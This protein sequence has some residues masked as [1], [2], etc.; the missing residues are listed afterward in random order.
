[1]KGSKL[2][3]CLLALILALA[4]ALGSCVG[5]SSPMPASTVAPMPSPSLRTVVAKPSATPSPT[6]A[7]PTRSEPT[8]GVPTATP[9]YTVTPTGAPTSVPATP[10]PTLPPTATA[11]GSASGA[12]IS[13]SSFTSSPAEILPGEAVTLTWHSTGEWATIY[14]LDGDGRMSEPWFKVGPSGTLVVET[15]SYLRNSA[16]F[17]LFAGTGEESVA[18]TASV[19]ITCPDE[20]F[21]PDPPSDCPLPPHTT[22]IVAEHFQHGLMLWLKASNERRPFDQ[23]LILF[24]DDVFSPRWQTV[25]DEWSEGMPESDPDIVAPGGCHQPIRG[26]GLVWRE[27]QDVRDRLGWATDEE[28]LIGEGSFQCAY[29]K[30]GRCYITGPS[31]EVYVLEPERS[32]WFVWTGPTPTP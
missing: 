23:V 2:T 9:T 6:L 32:G 15:K 18:A 30:Y 5:R 7:I 20:W 26:F 13:I 11:T 14:S 22:T 10:T 16:G 27:E 31:H 8:R 24:D 3:A 4:L 12:P 21:F 19:R 1:M 28:F 29:G 17:V 25:S